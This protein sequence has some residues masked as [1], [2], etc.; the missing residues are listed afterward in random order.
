MSRYILRRLLLMIPTLIGI[1][2][3]NF[4][5]VQAAPGGPIDQMLARFEGADAMASTRLE[6]GGEVMVR[7][8]SR[9]ARG[10]APRFI[11]Q[12][13]AQFGFDQPAHVRFLGMMRDYATFDFGTSF[14]RDRPVVEL[15][16]ERLPVSISL[17]LW[18]TL[19]VYLISI[20]LGIRKALHHG[21][22]FDVWTSGLVIVGY[23]I[24]GFLFAI[25]LIVL[26]AGGSYWDLFPLRGLT[27]PDFHELSTWGKVKDYAWHITLPVVA[28]TI[29]SFATLTMLT[30]NSFLD[31][32]HKQ[33]VLTARAKGASD[34][35]VLYG[36]VFRNAMLIIIAGLPGA[37]IAIFF[38]GSLLIEVIFS[39]E[40]LGLLGFEAVMQ[41]DY[42]V[43]F[44]TL[45][46]YTLIGLLLKLISDLTYVWV[47]PRIDFETRES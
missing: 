2:L 37:L 28:M 42:P 19:L 3:L 15:M 43:I 4:I 26:F 33:Y 9:G 13:E 5:I 14:F 38:T 22:R 44:G 16:I 8:E 32:I 39:L 20:P 46:L 25:L 34:G 18:T 36:H 27:S 40:G 1:M 23:A 24:P 30:K 29:G 45:Y 31:E 47:D 10:I 11:E 12:L 35:G 7:D 21:S 17:G 6:A 41:R